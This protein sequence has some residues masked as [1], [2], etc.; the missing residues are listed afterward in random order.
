LKARFPGGI[1]EG[2]HSA[3]VQVAAAIEDHLLDALGEGAFSYQ[4]SDG[5][6]GVTATAVSLKVAAQVFVNG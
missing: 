1:G 6:G 3:V 2:F 4:F 5:D